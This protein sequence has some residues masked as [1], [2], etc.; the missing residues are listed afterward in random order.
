MQ[1]VKEIGNSTEEGNNNAEA[2]VTGEAGRTA[3]GGEE[4]VERVEEKGNERGDEEDVVPISDDVA[5]GLENLVAP[6][7][8]VGVEV[9]GDGRVGGSSPEGAELGGR[10][11]NCCIHLP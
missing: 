3:N 9:G 7:H 6:E 5:V 4:E 2:G 10:R 1:Q 8:V 11:E